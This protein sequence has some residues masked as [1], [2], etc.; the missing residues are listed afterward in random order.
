MRQ[1]LEE[2]VVLE[3][4]LAAVD[5]RVEVEVLARL[6]DLP[7]ALVAVQPSHERLEVVHHLLVVGAGV[8]HT[9]L[10]LGD[11]VNPPIQCTNGFVVEVIGCRKKANMKVS[12]Q[13]CRDQRKAI[14]IYINRTL[15][16]TVA[17][18][19]N[20]SYPKRQCT[21]DELLLSSNRLFLPFFLRSLIFVLFLLLC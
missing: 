20:R 18:S 15:I 6:V 14:G 10:R 3:R 2:L 21:V 1:L 16:Q 13:E 4:L 8:V 5:A 7:D 12:Y 17:Q 11:L 9:R 19:I